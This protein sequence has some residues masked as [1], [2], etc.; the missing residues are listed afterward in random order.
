MSNLAGSVLTVTN[1]AG[2][3]QAI[4]LAT[5]PPDSYPRTTIVDLTVGTPVDATRTSTTWNLVIVGNAANVIL[6]GAVWIGTTKRTFSQNYVL[7]PIRN[8]AYQGDEIINSYGVAYETDYQTLLRSIACNFHG[9][10]AQDRSDL[11]DWYRTSHGRA[12]NSLFWP[13]PDVNDAL[14]GRWPQNFSEV[15]QVR[16][17]AVNRV[18]VPFQEASKGKP[19]F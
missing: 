10:S 4:T 2:L 9:A 5:L 18:T 13:N 11:E 1:G 7:E 19:V 16:G 6:G 17:S 14:L 8:L 3:S 12:R 15:L